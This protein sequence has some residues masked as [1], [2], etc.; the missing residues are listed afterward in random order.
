MIHLD[1]SVGEGGGQILRTALALSAWTG[2]PFSIHSIRA[3]RSKP[4]L[5]R[6]H[7]TAVQAVAKVCGACVEG[8][9]MGSRSLVFRPSDVVPGSHRFDIGTA[10]STTLVLQAVLPPLL[11]AARRS[12]VEITGGTHNP[13]SPPTDFLEK[14]FLPLVQRCGPDVQIELRRP[15]FFPAGG[16][17]IAVEITPCD[18]LQPFD[19]TRRGTLRSRRATARV[20]NLDLSIAEREI[21]VIRK[22]LQFAR[23]EVFTQELSGVAGAGNI[24]SIEHEF[25]HVTD[26]STGFGRRGFPAEKVARQAVDAAKRLV[27][28]G[29]PVGEH[30]ADQL[31]IPL[32]MAG[33]G[34]FRTHAP[35][36]HAQT[37]AE[38]IAAFL[39]VRFSMR[40]DGDGSWRIEV[41][42]EA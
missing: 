34:T 40:E 3:N 7:L 42:R 18:A 15:G 17:E 24:V 13:H 20:A 27:D 5:M 29:V 35:S 12:R 31:L 23:N 6:Q 14:S 38:I 41:R 36:L 28:S 2:Q 32:A 37:N 25:E 19:L 1:G 22:E 11:T 33:G 21:R 16:G 39:P 10:G 30:L 9:R 26:V 8:D 4:G